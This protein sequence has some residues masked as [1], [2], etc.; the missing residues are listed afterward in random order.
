M[1][2]QIHVHMPIYLLDDIY[3]HGVIELMYI[4]EGVLVVHILSICDTHY[5]PGLFGLVMLVSLSQLLCLL[6]KLIFQLCSRLIGVL[7]KLEAG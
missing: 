5:I 4:T 1:C 7:Q 6:D 3:Y 2:V